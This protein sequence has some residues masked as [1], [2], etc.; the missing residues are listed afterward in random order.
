MGK[1]TALSLAKMGASLV[2][3]CRNEDKGRIAMNEIIQK[4]GNSSIELLIADL[5]SQKEVRQVAKKFLSNHSRLDVLVNNAGTNFPTYAETEDGIE[6]TMAVNYFAPFLLTNLLLA[7][8]GSSAPSRVVNV[9]SEEHFG[10]KLDLSNLSQDRIMG[11]VGSRAYGRSKLALVLFTYELA[12]RLERNKVTANCVDPGA[13]RTKIWGQ[14]G[15]LT[16]IMRLLS[17]FMKGPA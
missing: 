8:L 15:A 10:A 9:T 17:L 3:V 4:S 1:E 13:V 5:Q 2:L 11:T 16:P 14:A 6:R 7:F 12:R